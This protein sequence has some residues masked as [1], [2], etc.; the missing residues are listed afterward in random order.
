MN[1]Q[2]RSWERT[3]NMV[4]WQGRQGKLPCKNGLEKAPKWVSRQHGAGRPPGDGLCR[5]LLGL[6]GKG[7][8]VGH[9]QAKPV[10]QAALRP[11]WQPAL[12]DP[13]RRPPAPAG[14][15]A[16]GGPPRGGD[17]GGA[18]GGRGACRGG[19][20]WLRRRRAACRRGGRG[21]RWRPRAPGRGSWL[22]AQWQWPLLR[23]SQAWQG[24][25]MLSTGLEKGSRCADKHAA[26]AGQSAAQP[27]GRGGRQEAAGAGG[28]QGGLTRG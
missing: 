26:R 28:R 27:A 2:L 22:C 13:A 18:A 6:D 15:A 23:R 12:R 5:T 7:C 3:T 17:P 16:G 10:G 24:S 20:G 19:A 9:C 14:A 25:R 1:W 21:R 11:A 4:S 8:R